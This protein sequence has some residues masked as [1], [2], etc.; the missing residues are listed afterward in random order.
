TAFPV[1]RTR[2]RGM[3]ACNHGGKARAAELFSAS[4]R[5]PARPVD[6]S[7]MLSGTVAYEEENSGRRCRRH[8]RKTADVAPGRAR[9]SIRSADGA[10]TV[11]SEIQAECARLEIRLRVRWLSGAGAEEP[12]HKRSKAFGQRM[13]RFQFFQSA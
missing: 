7:R 9:I 8:A 12:N 10:G 1:S 2:N 6:C 11:R 4:S 13:D 5:F 3:L